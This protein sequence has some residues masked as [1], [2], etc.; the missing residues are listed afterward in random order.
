MFNKKSLT[1]LLAVCLTSAASLSSFAADDSKMETMV[2]TATRTPLALTKTLASVTTL[3]RSDIERLQA[4]NVP[5]LLSRV[6]G[7]NLSQNGGEG[8]NTGIFIRGAE[9]NQTLILID[10]IR[11]SSATLGSTAIQYLNPDQIERI[12]IVRGPRSALYGSDAIGG[13]IQIFTKQGSKDL[14]TSFTVGAGSNETQKISA[15]ASAGTD[16]TQFNVTASYYDTQGFSRKDATLVSPPDN[17]DDAYRNSSLSA[18]LS[19]QIND[20][21]LWSFSL[22]H[23]EGES[24]YDFFS[25]VYNDFSLTSANTALQTTFV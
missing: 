5:E 14:K 1:T 19:H 25:L 10:G 13:V 20:N 2:V 3:D 16:T 9:A 18:S 6:P 17:D 4:T 15:S 24:E 23:N 8:S 11:S 22:S 21:N 12:E 7:I